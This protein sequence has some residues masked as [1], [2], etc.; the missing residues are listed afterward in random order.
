MNMA[1]YISIDVHQ[2]ISV[3]AVMNQ[4]GKIVG[5]AV[6]KIKP[7]TIINFLKDQQGMVRV[8][9]ERGTFGNWL[10]DVI[11]FHVANAAGYNPRKNNSCPILLTH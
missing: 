10:Y 8:T 11:Q 1:K 7:T 3:F 5:E 9:F 6:F 2:A 4:Q